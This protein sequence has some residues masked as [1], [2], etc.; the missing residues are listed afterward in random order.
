LSDPESEPESGVFL[1]PEVEALLQAG[2]ARD[3]PA[4]ALLCQEGKAIDR[5]FLLTIGQVEIAKSIAGKPRALATTGPGSV[6]CLMAA[7]DGNPCAV[8]M[9]TLGEATVVEITRS[10]L[11]ALLA[12]AQASG[13]NLVHDLTL[14]AIRRLRGATDELAQTLFRALRSSPRAGR[15]DPD[16]LAR[17][18][19][20]NHAWP[21]VRLAA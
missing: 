10:S 21:C 9:H 5:L 7:L 8:S 19:A 20:G 12:P 11:L 15:I 16:S 6:L 1:G 2:Q 17:I 14:V 18:Q 3:L 4:R 13:S